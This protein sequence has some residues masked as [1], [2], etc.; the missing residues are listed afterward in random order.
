MM[1]EVQV[2]YHIESIVGIPPFCKIHGDFLSK[3][4]PF[5]WNQWT[6][7][8]TEKNPLSPC[9][10]GLGYA[11]LLYWTAVA[12]HI[13]AINDQQGTIK[14][15]HNIEDCIVHLY[16]FEEINTCSVDVLAYN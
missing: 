9:N 4:P 7:P 2:D 1:V 11:S 5:C 14:R 13:H 10:C 12:G 6:M 16:G 8:K 15:A 3:T